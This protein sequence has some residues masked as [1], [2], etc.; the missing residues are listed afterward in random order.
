MD[1]KVYP[2][3]TGDIYVLDKHDRHFLRGGVN[4]DLILVSVFNPPLVGTERHNL[5]N[6]GG[7]SY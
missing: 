7:S 1:G 6:G 2:I 3:K 5:N 4:T